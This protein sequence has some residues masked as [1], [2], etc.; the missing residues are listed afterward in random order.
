L[1]TTVGTAPA[2]FFFAAVGFLD[3]TV[4]FT[5][6]LDLFFAA[7]DFLDAAVF[8]LTADGF[9]AA[10]LALAAIIFTPSLNF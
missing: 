7:V 5:A 4:F 2:D 1:R 3:A 8:F 6:P 10:A 9:F